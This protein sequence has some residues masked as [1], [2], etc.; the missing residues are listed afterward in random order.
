MNWPNDYLNHILTG[1]CLSIMKDIPDDSIDLLL[2]DP[3]YAGAGMKYDIFKDGDKDAVTKL[4]LDFVALARQK[5][6]IVIFPSGKYETELSLFHDAPPQWRMCW[7]KCACGGL[8]KVGFNDWEMMMVYGK[9]ICVNAHDHFT[10]PNTEKMGNYGHPCPKPLKWA[11]WI[12]NRFSP[13]KGIVMDCFAGSGTV[14]LAAER[15]G[16]SWVGCDISAEYCKI[17][18]GRIDKERSQLKLP[19]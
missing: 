16:R 3:P 2:T 9:K 6:K 5:A 1:D 17:A 14:L 19:F 11:E 4:V 8:S 18:Q 12:I 10:V 15:L 7:Y 13:V